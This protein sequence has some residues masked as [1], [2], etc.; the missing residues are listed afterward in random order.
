[1]PFQSEKQRR[2]LWANEPKIARDWADTYG[3]RIEKNDGGIMRES[4]R[5]GAA[6]TGGMKGTSDRGMSVGD[7]SGSKGGNGHADKG[8][9]TY[10]IGPTPDTTSGGIKKKLNISPFVNTVDETPVELGLMSTTK[11]GRLKAAI[12]LRNLTKALTYGKEDDTVVNSLSDV[13]NLLDPSL[14]FNTQVGPV[15][16]NAT[17]SD[18]VQ[19][20]NASINKNNWGAN[21]NYNAIT[22]EPSWNFGYSKTFNNGGLARLL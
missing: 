12:N 17:Y 8:W 15:D 10:A 7:V 14:S 9:Q 5:V 16:L 21:I 11:L 22:G 13:R 19:D 6:A 20:I 3:S 2:Y 1:M 4:F 18:D